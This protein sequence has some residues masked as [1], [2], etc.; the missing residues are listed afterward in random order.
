MPLLHFYLLKQ[1]SSLSG[2]FED[3]VYDCKC[4]CKQ[5]QRPPRP[6]TLMMDVSRIYYGL[7]ASNRTGLIKIWHIQQV[8]TIVTMCFSQKSLSFSKENLLSEVF[9]DTVHLTVSFSDVIIFVIIHLLYCTSTCYI[10][11]N[12]YVITF[13]CHNYWHKYCVIL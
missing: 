11:D 6:S 8:W 3:I 7:P 2:V 1:N 9:W 10:F 5:F 4:I 13:G 12:V